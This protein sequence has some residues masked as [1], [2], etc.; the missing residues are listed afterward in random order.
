M[1][2]KAW[3]TCKVVVLP[4][5]TYC[6]VLCRSRWRRRRRCFSALIGFRVNEASDGYLFNS[7]YSPNF[8]GHLR[9]VHL[10]WLGLYSISTFSLHFLFIVLECRK[11]VFQ[12]WFGMLC[13]LQ[14][15]EITSVIINARSVIT[16]RTKNADHDHIILFV[17]SCTLLVFRMDDY[18][19]VVQARTSPPTR[20]TFFVTHPCNEDCVTSQKNVC[21]GG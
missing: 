14:G 13:I 20:P 9:D 10:P 6:S 1:Y 15:N 4:I 12:C 2:K 3:C 21:V 19:T 17:N 8:F 7:S 5:E 18:I 11:S 16:V